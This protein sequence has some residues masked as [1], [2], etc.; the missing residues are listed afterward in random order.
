MV[1]K[2]WMAIV[3]ISLVVLLGVLCTACSGTPTASDSAAAAS[4]SVAQASSEA[5]AS[6]SA[7]PAGASATAA[8]TTLPAHEGKM[9]M[10][11]V[12]MD[13]TNEYFTNTIEGYKQFAA[14]TNG[15][16]EIEYYDGQNSPEKQVEVCENLIN[17]GVD[18]ILINAIDAAA[19][20]DVINNALSKGILVCQYPNVENLTS[21]LE[22]DEYGWGYMLGVEAGNWIKEKLD[23]K[24]TVATFAMMELESV[25][26]R[27]NGICDGITSVCDPANI[28]FVEPVNTVNQDE[29]YTGMESIL[30]AHPECRVALATTDDPAVGAYEAIAAA[31]KDTDDWFIGGCDGTSQALQLIGEDTIYRCTAANS[32]KTSENAFWLA[33]NLAKAYYGLPYLRDCVVENKIVNA[34]NIDEYVNSAP[35]YQ[36]DDDLKAKLGL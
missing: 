36:L 14:L 30:Q 21:A 10:G 22:F 19:V 15:Q 3:A 31:G 4:E 8:P 23:G 32:K 13:M 34:S 27:W 1:S 12:V 9:K 28:T 24:A 17:M 33:E 6:E 2:K 35:V 29:A 20:E 18:G 7:S 16:V 25:V 11:A 5:E 26:K